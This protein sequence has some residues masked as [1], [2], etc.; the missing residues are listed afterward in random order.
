MNNHKLAEFNDEYTL[1]EKQVKEY[2]KNGHVSLPGVATKEEI[3]SYRPYLEQEFEE[4][5]QKNVDS[6]GYDGF[7]SK[8]LMAITNLWLRNTNMKKFVLAKRFAKIAADLMDSEAVRLYYD[9]A[10]FKKPG[11]IP[12]PVHIDPF[13][14]NPDKVVTMWMP[15]VDIKD[16]LSSLNFIS[17]SHMP[18]NKDLLPRRLITNAIKKG[19]PEKNYG[20]MKM[21]DV[22]FHAG[23]I[24]HGAPG[25][26]TDK[27]RGVMTITYFEDGHRLNDPGNDP[28]KIKH[29]KKHFSD[30]KPG[31]EVGHDLHPI[32]YRQ[33]RLGGK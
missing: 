28:E 15:F 23:R 6:I 5:F 29:F 18:E 27:M 7:T 4:F 21:G 24:I 33:P 3:M 12:T 8:A 20:D 1:S 26:L 13:C 30:K 10:L 19:L 22:T 16:G 9:V 25:N 31:D 2:R 17:G 14:L 32:L 11:G